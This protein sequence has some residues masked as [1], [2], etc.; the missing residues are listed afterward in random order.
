MKFSSLAQHMIY[1]LRIIYHIVLVCIFFPFQYI[2]YFN[3]YGIILWKNNFTHIICIPILFFSRKH[4][5]TINKYVYGFGYFSSARGQ[6]TMYCTCLLKKYAFNGDNQLT[7][8]ILRCLFQQSQLFQRL[9]FFFFFIALNLILSRQI[10][11][12]TYIIYCTHWHLSRSFHRYR[13]RGERIKTYIIILIYVHIT[14]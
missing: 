1:I 14:R 3:V 13:I 6:F 12:H 2:F 5:L 7:G 8:M 4:N 11:K 10:F 9:F